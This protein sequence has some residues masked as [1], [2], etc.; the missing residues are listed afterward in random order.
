MNK[1]TWF[2][3]SLVCCLS[4]CASDESAAPQLHPQGE[5]RLLPLETTQRQV[6]AIL[7]GDDAEMNQVQ[8][9]PEAVT[10]PVLFALA[11]QL[12]QQEHFHD[13]MF[14]YFTAQLRARSDANKSLDVSVQQGVTKLSEQFGQAI[15]AYAQANPQAM[16]PAMIEALKWDKTAP[17]QYNPRWVALHGSEVWSQQDYA[18]MPM[19]RWAEIDRQTRDDFA[20]GFAR[21]MVNLRKGSGLALTD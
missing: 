2:A 5:Y 11:F 16:E 6:N 15:A 7:Q 13:A 9:H 21:Q 1:P 19:A 4:G 10:P 12:Y 18:F 17:R 14:W 8:L 3:I 20:R